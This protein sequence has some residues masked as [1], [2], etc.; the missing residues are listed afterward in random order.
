MARTRKRAAEIESGNQQ[1]API[2]AKRRRKASIPLEIQDPA[3][4]D[5]RVEDTRQEEAQV[6]KLCF[7]IKGRERKYHQFQYVPGGKDYISSRAVRGQCYVEMG[8]LM[9]S[10]QSL[11]A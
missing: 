3:E 10:S 2:R 9:T 1:S 11:A 8:L 6:I 5:D 4:H 7:H